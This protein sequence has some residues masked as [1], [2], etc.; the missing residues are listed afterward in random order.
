M[1]DLRITA[2]PEQVLALGVVPLD[3]PGRLPIAA[4]NLDD[5]ADPL[6]LAHLVPPDHQFVPDLC[7]HRHVLDL[8]ADAPAPDRAP[9]TILYPTALGVSRLS[10]ASTHRVRGRVNRGYRGAGKIG[11]HRPPGR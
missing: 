7:P 8:A 2:R 11:T 9:T 5:P 3:Q 6:V 10:V 1:H 4:P